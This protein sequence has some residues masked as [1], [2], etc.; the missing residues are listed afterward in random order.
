MSLSLYDIQ[1]NWGGTNPVGLDEY[2]QGGSYIGIGVHGGSI[3]YSGNAISCENFVGTTNSY[4]YSYNQQTGGD[5]PNDGCAWAVEYLNGSSGFGLY[6]T[7]AYYG[8]GGGISYSS[9][10]NYAYVSQ[11]KVTALNTTVY[12]S[13]VS[14]N[15]NGESYYLGVPYGDINSSNIL[16]VY[17]NNGQG[18]PGDTGYAY[19]TAYNRSNWSAMTS[20]LNYFQIQLG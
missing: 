14:G 7:V 8:N 3:P 15:G 16:T 2:Y 13:T 5:Q 20:G 6:V 4:G 12:A 10:G 1:A 17:G 18:S 19:A 11:F 9:W